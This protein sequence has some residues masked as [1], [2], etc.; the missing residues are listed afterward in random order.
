MTKAAMAATV[1]RRYG[2]TSLLYML[3]T[4]CKLDQFVNGPPVYKPVIQFLNWLA[5]FQLYKQVIPFMNQAERFE[6]W[7]KGLQATRTG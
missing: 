3:Q 2:S 4:N 7:L 6:S 5:G 1:P